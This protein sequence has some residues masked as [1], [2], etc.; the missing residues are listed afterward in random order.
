MSSSC[1][2]IGIEAMAKRH[3]ITKSAS[4]MGYIDPL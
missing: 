3:V 1:E 4:E 2:V